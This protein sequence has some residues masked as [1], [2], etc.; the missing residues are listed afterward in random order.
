MQSVSKLFFVVFVL[1]WALI[2][3]QGHAEFQKSQYDHRE[4]RAFYLDNGMRVLI[5]S[6][7]EAIDSAVS[8]AVRVGGGDDPKT[9]AGLAHLL[10]HMLFLG[11]EK[12]PE[13]DGYRK[14]IEKHGG[15]T[16][17][18]TSIDITN[19]NFSIDPSYLEPALDRF[20][21]FFKTPLFPVEQVE[22]ELGVVDAEYQ[23]RTQRD[24][25]RRW[26]A[27]RHTYNPNHPSAKFISGTAETL[28]GDV[29]DDLVEFFNNRY[30]SNLMNLVVLGRESLDVLQDWVEEKFD[31]VANKQAD[32]LQTSEPLF[33]SD[34]FPLLL[35]VK[36]LKDNPNLTLLFP[37]RDLQPLWRE[38]PD[39]YISHLLGHEG[40]GS[41]LSI[42]KDAG[43]AEG[44]YVSP[45][46][47]GYRSYSINVRISLTDEGFRNWETVAA[48]VFQYIREIDTRGIDEWRFTETKIL[49]E[50]SYQF[51]EIED[52]RN[53]VTYIASALHKY[54]K[55]EILPALYLVEKY[56]PELISSLLRELNPQN[57]LA[58]L[59]SA[60]IETDKV[61]PYIR[62][63]Y[64]LLEIPKETQTLWNKDVADSSS[65]LPERN[66][67][68][69]QN[70]ALKADLQT[71]VP[72]RIIDNPGYELWYQTD[73]SFDVPKASFFVSIRSPVVKNLTDSILL[74]L[75]TRAINDQLNEFAYPAQVAGLEFSLY[76][77]QRGLS[78]RISGY[79]DKQNVLMERIVDVLKSPNFD[80]E[81][82]LR[83]KDEIKR[84]IENRKKENAYT[85]TLA[86]FYSLLIE[87]YWTDDEELKAL[88]E[89]EFD[90]LVDY[91]RRFLE[92]VDIVVLSHGNVQ[93]EAS[94][95]MGNYV[96]A[97]LLNPERVAEVGK[98]DV[99]D[100]P[101]N[102]GFSRS[103]EIQNEDS[104]I[105]VY[106]QGTGRSI[107]E[108][109]KFSLLTYTIQVPFFSDLR[110]VQQLGYVVFAT[111]IPIGQVPGILFVI[112]S[113]TASPDEMATAISNFLGD[114]SNRLSEMPEDEFENYR[115]GLVN[116]ILEEDATLGDRT[117]RYWTAIDQK[118]YDF[119]QL[120]RVA[121]SLR[122][123]QREDFQ[124]FVT[125]LLSN[126]SNAQLTVLGYGRNHERTQLA[127]GASVVIADRDMFKK[128]Q[129]LFP[130]L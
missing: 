80:Y 103:V 126:K 6:D 115:I 81:E 67:F 63:E 104:A 53:Y 113:P 106:I 127:E 56:D 100:L 66:I 4:Y 102:S 46:N 107:E 17:A 2:P 119:D 79:N 87:P 94:E 14:F 1:S 9:R 116:E 52:V 3:L 121:E 55:N 97:N 88:E 18:Y 23:M 41:L 89:T 31:P 43:W 109:V 99:I 110:S 91:S 77:H 76:G 37:V 95:M 105:A 29:K 118:D 51:S 84:E 27:M 22:R 117:S 8:I 64:S 120:E 85:Q 33:H 78:F 82:F 61:T 68:L 25:V 10:E 19:Y 36:S 111:Y 34:K 30:S 5:I 50:L 28:S 70:I 90:A 86:E 39:S 112:Q 48:Y 129:N 71:D 98:N 38:S 11:T 57:V 32:E 12:Y 69:P 73:T 101:E 60:E 21:E 15:Q 62:S 75:Y 125:D 92:S 114:F 74:S 16:N 47:A 58:I 130:P 108:R 42:L 7:S 13:L 45:G 128:Q 35:K 20:S 40:A 123:L 44:L 26:A 93:R 72:Q 124:K 96:T 59:T 122:I 65:W 24:A 83:H 49:N 54:P